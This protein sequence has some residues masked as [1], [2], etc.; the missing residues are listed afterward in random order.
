M[1]T[2]GYGAAAVGAACT[3]AEELS[4]AVGDERLL[5]PSLWRLGVFHEV[6]AN[7]GRQEEIGNR[8]LRLARDST[9]PTTRL[10]GLM[11][12]GPPAIQ[13]GELQHA[14]GLLEEAIALAEPLDARALVETFGHNHQVTS[15]GFLACALSLLAVDDGA[16]QTLIAEGLHRA[17]ELPNAIDEA[18]ALFLAAFCAA[19]VDDAEVAQRRA[20]E[21]TA[22]SRRHGLP[23]FAATGT[24]IGGWSEARQGDADTG[25]RTVAEGIDAFKATGARMMLHAFL[26][27]LADAQ[28]RAGDLEQ[29]L[30]SVES[31]LSHVDASTRF[32]EAELRRLKGELLVA[33]HPEE[34][35][36]ALRAAVAI[37]H[38]QQ[39]TTLKRRAHA[40]LG[41]LAAR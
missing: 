1:S 30:A 37:A 31:G 23:L 38:E 18:F 26:A 15:R 6:R 14:R 5:V 33:L 25:A 17:R 36:R 41:Q 7:F 4:R 16:P 24:V 27:L 2:K 35:E 10:S 40:S 34:A 11:L 28:R 21:L 20:E 29:A 32:Y 12:L 19:I 13:K 3:R 9:Q 8:L 39:A 22:L